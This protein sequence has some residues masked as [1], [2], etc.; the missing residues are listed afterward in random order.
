LRA[1]EILRERLAEPTPA[2]PKNDPTG[3]EYYSTFRVAT[4]L[5]GLVHMGSKE[6]LE[7]ARS[8][9]KKHPFGDFCF[10]ITLSAVGTKNELNLLTDYVRSGEPG[11]ADAALS[12]VGRFGDQAWPVYRAGFERTGM[13]RRLSVFGA[14]HLS[15]GMEPTLRRAAADDPT[16][17]L[18]W[19][20]WKVEQ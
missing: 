4:S 18:A 7:A 1:L 20:W 3:I 10:A 8:G 2:A 15:R 11:V 5:V 12:H 17:K 6:A 16:A 13:T 19:T 14:S 9:A